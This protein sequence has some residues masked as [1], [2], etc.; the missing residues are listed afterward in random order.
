VKAH[1][2][3]DED[4]DRGGRGR[5]ELTLIKNGAA[6]CIN[7]MSTCM[8]TF[9][10]YSVL[11]NVRNRGTRVTH[12][13]EMLCRYWE[14]NPGPLQGQQGLWRDAPSH[15]SSPHEYLLLSQ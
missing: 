14:L 2:D 4:G 7:K 12:G 8:S 13:C 11:G 9:P 1:R 10:V 15:L 3:G 5:G 6:L